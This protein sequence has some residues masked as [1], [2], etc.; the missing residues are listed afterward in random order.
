MIVCGRKMEVM[1][2]NKATWRWNWVLNQ[3]LIILLL[4]MVPGIAGA[5]LRIGDMVPSITLT[6]V[7]GATIRI[8]ESLNGKVV[9]LHF[10]Q[11]GCTSC[12]LEMPAM[13]GL[14]SKYRRKGLKILAVNVGQRKEAVNSFASDLRVSYPILIDADGRSASLYGVTDVPRTYVVDRSGIVR[15]RILGG[16]TPEIL[17]KLILSLL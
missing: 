14:Y 3:V 11:I 16:A 2:P 13:D 12:R 4:L 17:K 15:Y 10:W 9:I 8:P 7:N 6:G 1:V 5:A